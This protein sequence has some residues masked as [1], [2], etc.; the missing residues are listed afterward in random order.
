MPGG[1]TPNDS[2][3]TLLKRLE[4]SIQETLNRLIDSGRI[5]D[6][7]RERASAF[8]SRLDALQRRIQADR[9]AAKRVEMPAGMKSDFDLLAWDFRR[10][11]AEVDD[12]FGAPA[13]GPISG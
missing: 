5:A 13:K 2:P 6:A 8:R 12:E 4:A 7:H 11:V 3:E 9:D 10:W 1:S